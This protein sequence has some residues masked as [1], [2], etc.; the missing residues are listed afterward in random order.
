MKDARWP[1][2]A[3]VLLLAACSA[4]GT[5]P[6]ETPSPS[7]SVAPTEFPSPV[8]RTA[9][10]LTTIRLEG[11]PQATQIAIDNDVAW[12]RLTDGSAARVDT[13]T[14]AVVTFPVGTGEFG[15][16]AVGEGSVWVTTFDEDKVSRID[17]AT[18]T[19]V[20][21]I[22]VGVNPEGIAVTTG[23][24]WV[25]NHRGGSIWRIDPMTDKVVAK[26]EVGPT[27]RSGPKDIQAAFGALWTSVPNASLVIR[28]DPETNEVA[29][30]DVA[31]VEYLIIG[32]ESV[33][34]VD[35]LAQVNEIQ[36]DSNEV[37]RQFEPDVLPWV[38][39]N[40][41]FW[42]TDGSDLLR[43]DPASFAATEVWHV[44]GGQTGYAAIAFH[45]GS[46]SLLTDDGFLLEVELLS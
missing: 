30:I 21:E 43:L 29:A 39:G 20:A 24:V 31:A 23:A 44:A 5:S 8:E 10:V 36:P 32:T 46:V 2:A 22:P 27:G 6:S 34:A 13:A 18:N 19:V 35:A 38:F 41:A 9:T 37:V 4:G 11:L 12:L 16:L 33:Y 28:L 14:G 1:A 26:V 3:M 25:S 40:G 42:G 7:A 15:S 17:P 45:G